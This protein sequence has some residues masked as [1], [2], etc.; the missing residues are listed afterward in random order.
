MLYNRKQLH[1]ILWIKRTY[2]KKN[3]KSTNVARFH[4]HKVAKN[5][6]FIRQ[7]NA[8]CQGLGRGE[9]VGFLVIDVFRL[10]LCVLRMEG[11]DGCT[12]L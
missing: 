10:R 7:Q 6:H 3:K 4:M 5:N 12:A 2:A 1:A 11:S 9:N 8:T